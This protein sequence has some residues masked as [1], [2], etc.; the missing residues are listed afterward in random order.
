MTIKSNLK[1]KSDIQLPTQQQI[2]STLTV[3]LTGSTLCT[4][5][6]LEYLTPQFFK[7]DARVVGLQ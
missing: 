6:V 7:H 1:K 3:L 5:P 2:K 4:F